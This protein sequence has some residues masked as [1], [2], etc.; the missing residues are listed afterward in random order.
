MLKIILYAG[1]NY[2]TVQHDF[3]KWNYIHVSL[4]EQTGIYMQ[5]WTPV[6]SMQVSNEQV[7]GRLP[8]ERNKIKAVLTC[9]HNLCFEQK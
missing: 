5:L 8:C 2:L 9:T 4:K 7:L 1:S 3:Q 6:A